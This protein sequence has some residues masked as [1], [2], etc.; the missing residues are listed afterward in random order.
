MAYTYFRNFIQPK[1]YINK[2]YVLHSH[3]HVRT[4]VFSF[5]LAPDNQNSFVLSQFVCGPKK[6]FR[7]LSPSP[8]P[9]HLRSFGFVC[10]VYVF[11]QRFIQKAKARLVRWP[12]P[13]EGQ[14]H[15]GTVWG[16]RLWK[17]FCKIFSESS[18]YLLGQHS[19]CSTAQRSVELSETFYKTFLTT[20]RST[21]YKFEISCTRI[22]NRRA[23]TL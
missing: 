19:R 5:L 6:P 20:R 18:P 23:L 11:D 12:P 15:I 7:R 13:R 2:A 9:S 17:R 3:I 8:S 4:L 22:H 21:L 1:G 14:S 16:V 10:Y